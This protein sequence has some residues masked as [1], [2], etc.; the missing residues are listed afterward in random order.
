MI[1]RTLFV[2]L[3]ALLGLL[4]SSGCTQKTA[5]AYPGAVQEAPEQGGS[6][7]DRGVDRY[8]N[9]VDVRL[10]G[11]TEGAITEVFGKVVS[12]VPGVVSA[13]RYSSRIVP[14]NPQACW[15]LWRVTTRG[16]AN[17]FTLQTEMM[18]MFSEVIAAGGYVDIYSVPYRYSPP[19]IGLLKGMRPMDATSRSITFI[20]D[21]ELARD[22]EM[23]GY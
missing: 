2:L 15:I 13:K 22:R 4:M 16:E 6:I 1:L 10:E 19:E 23:A 9:L 3:P 18:E 11:A 20:V 21:R 8:T 7:L 14:D 5:V 12:S 17:T